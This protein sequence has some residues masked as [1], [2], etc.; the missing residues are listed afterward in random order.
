[1]AKYPRRRDILGGIGAAGAASL[2]GCFGFFEGDDEDGGQTIELGLLMGVTGEL[3]QLGPPIRDAAELVPEQ[4]NNADTDFEVDTQFEDTNT[5]PTQGV[6]GA[7]ALVNAGYPMICGAL[8]SEVTQQ[9]AESTAVPNQVTMCSPAST[10]PDITDLND[11]D[12]LFRTAATDALQGVVL[13]QIANEELGHDTASVLALNNAYGSGLSDGFA[14]SF[15][16]DFGGTITE[17]VSFTAGQQSYTSQLQSALDGN[18][19]TMLIIG[20]PESGV[21]I[22]RDFYSS[23]DRSDM[24]ILVADGLQDSG[25]PD[26]VGED[27]S[28]V[29][30]TAPLGAG[31]G[32]EFFQEQFEDTY[33]EPPEGPFLRQSYDAAAVLVLAHAASDGTGSGVRDNMRTVT[34]G[35]GEQ[36]TPETL[37]DGIEMAANGDDIVYEGVSGP[38]AFDENGDLA[39][40]TY[41]YFQFT[42][43]GDIETISEVTP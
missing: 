29:R 12:F 16:N 8:G 10:S 42:A 32:V 35:E 33:G 22:F 21:Q 15:E 1:M 28:N 2:A 19:G 38:V 43:E 24:D 41:E 17:Q 18:P 7:E 36:I 9:V 30:G 11:D 25:L 5:S 4:V 13:A 27:M 40:A 37:V 23:F 31:P 26:S 39:S 6:D 20:Y 14:T 3:E 34:E